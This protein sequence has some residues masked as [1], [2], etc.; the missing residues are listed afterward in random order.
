MSKHP[1]LLA[2]F[3]V[4]ILLPASQLGA[5]D[6][7]PPEEELKTIKWV[8]NEDYEPIG[9]PNAKKG[10]MIRS[11][12]T[13][14]PPTLRTEGPQSNLITL[15]QIHSY[16]YESLLSTHPTTLEFIPNLATHWCISED[17]MTFWFK[18][19]PDA[20]WADGSEVTADDVVA[21]YEHMIDPDI[22]DPFAKMHYTRYWEKPVALSKA[23]VKVKCKELNWRL[24]YYF[25]GMQIYP[26]KECKIPGAEYLEKY[27]WK[28][29]TGSGPYH[30]KPE[31]LKKEESFILTRRKNYWAE[32]KKFS[33]GLY[34][35]DKIKWI[36]I[37]D[38]TIAFESFKKGE[39]DF[40]SVGRAQ[41]WHEECDFDKVQ[42]GWIQ[43]RKIY[44]QRPIGFSG[45]V[46]N[47]RKP[48]F[49]DIKV[50]KA[51]C[52]LFNRQK[53]MDKLFF[54][55]YEY[56]DSYYPGR[57]WGNPENPKIRYNPDLAA[58]LLAEAGFKGRDKNGWLIGPDGKIFEL[59]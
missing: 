30:L 38:D 28:L 49:D 55:E 13:S 29:W 21:T 1:W 56:T 14:Y 8:T 26:A 53:L 5:E 59:T 11:W 4:G 23:V 12:W 17:K 37:K 25:G 36:V 24:F 39:L 27:Q 54:N 40:Y 20:K 57:M 44:N 15:S 9:D 52:Y 47:M 35:F 51:F 48:P 42:N 2:I 6:T 58:Q 46:F 22:K 10:G 16:L 18:I 50:R 43:K 41:R 31:D 34:N 33:V 19:D 7:L 32:K 3:A 45:F